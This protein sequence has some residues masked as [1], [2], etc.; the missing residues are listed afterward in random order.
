VLSSSWLSAEKSTHAVSGSASKPPSIRLLDG[1]DQTEQAP[2][3]CDIRSILP[4]RNRADESGTPHKFRSSATKV[5]CRSALHLRRPPYSCLPR[6]QRVFATIRPDASQNRVTAFCP[7]W[8][9]APLLPKA[10][11]RHR[12]DDRSPVALLQLIDGATI[13]ASRSHRF[14][15]GSLCGD[16][17]IV[18]SLFR[19]RVSL[20]S[21]HRVL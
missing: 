12:Y 1:I 21:I 5:S 7:S 18:A 15:A 9:L 16:Q 11:C 8:R 6:R 10:F 17:A 13:R 4:R 20:I 14:L 3:Q 19:R 2:D